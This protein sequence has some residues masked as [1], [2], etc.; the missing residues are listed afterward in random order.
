EVALNAVRC[1]A[2]TLN[3]ALLM[4]EKFGVP[5][6]TLGMAPLGIDTVQNWVM[7]IAARLGKEE[8]AKRLVEVEVEKAEKR[9]KE[10]K[11]LLAGKRVAV[12][13]GPGHSVAV[14]KF[15]AELGMAPIIASSLMAD[16]G[17]IQSF[18]NIACRKNLRAPE[19]LSGEEYEACAEALRRLNPD[20]VIGGSPERMLSHKLGLNFL[21]IMRYEEP[22]YGFNGAVKF[23]RDLCRVLKLPERVDVPPEIATGRAAVYGADHPVWRWQRRG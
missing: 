10:A 14:F 20:L 1:E 23:V 21:H 3:A 11:S 8:E 13:G 2:S 7:N 15:C 4:E 19:I 12:Y 6:F 17:A 9:I 16:R 22:W 5:Y 18:K